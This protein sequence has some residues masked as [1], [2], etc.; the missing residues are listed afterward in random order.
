MERPKPKRDKGNVI[1]RGNCFRIPEF[2]SAAQV[3]LQISFEENQK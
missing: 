1:E 3:D 2:Y